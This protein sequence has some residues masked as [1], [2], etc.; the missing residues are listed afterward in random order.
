M[1]QVFESPTGNVRGIDIGVWGRT[2]VV[3]SLLVFIMSSC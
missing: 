3:L 2:R 1:I